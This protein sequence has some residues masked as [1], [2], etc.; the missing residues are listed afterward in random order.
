MA[1]NAAMP[2]PFD[3]SDAA[4]ERLHELG[5]SVGIS[6][7]VGPAG[8]V[9]TVDALKGERRIVAHAPTTAEAYRELIEQV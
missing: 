9:W 2:T 8:Q 1:M 6:S 7:T 5:W 3:P 4:H